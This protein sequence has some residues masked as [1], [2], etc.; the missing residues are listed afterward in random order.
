MHDGT[1]PAREYVE[2]IFDTAKFLEYGADEQEF[3]NRVVTNL[4]PS[5]LAHAAFMDRPHTKAELLRIIETLEERASV[6]VERKQ[7]AE[8]KKVVRSEERPVRQGESNTQQR[9]GPKCWGCG[10]L[11]HVRRNC[12]KN[13]GPR[14]GQASVGQGTP[15]GRI[16]GALK[17]VRRSANELPLW[18]MA[19]FQLG[20]LPTV[21]DSKILQ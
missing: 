8:V 2:Q 15:R 13:P 20:R 11:G 14:N 6:R 21:V 7:Q 4:H 1:K 9:R 3:V 17:P 16:L 12:C 10:Q 5:V 19:E 18:F